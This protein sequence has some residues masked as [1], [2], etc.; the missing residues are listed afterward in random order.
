M[1]PWHL[2][3]HHPV[4]QWLLTL[5]N[6]AL[7]LTLLDGIYNVR[8]TQTRLFG[9][10]DFVWRLRGFPATGCLLHIDDTPDLFGRVCRGCRHMFSWSAILTTIAEEIKRNLTCGLTKKR[11]LANTIRFSLG[12]SVLSWFYNDNG[13]IYRCIMEGY[14]GQGWHLDRKIVLKKVYYLCRTIQLYGF[15]LTSERRKFLSVS[16]I[17]KSKQKFFLVTIYN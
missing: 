5:L 8:T 10:W 7:T 13:R 17:S 1:T 11:N 3:P 9:V 14:M 12:F 2:P 4:K 6:G 15:A 16:W